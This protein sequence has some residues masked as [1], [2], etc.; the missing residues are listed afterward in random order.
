M[1]RFYKAALVVML[2]CGMQV[3]AQK[4]AHVQMD[5]LIQLMPETKQ[6]MDIAQAY[7]KDLEKQVSTMKAEF[8][9]K[10]QDYLTNKDNYSD[11][12]RKTKEEELQTLNQRIE[13][14][15][16]QAQQDYQK[17]YTELSKPI[18]EKAKKAIDIIAKE[19][20]Y[21]YVLDTS[22]GVVLFSEPGDDLLMAVK[23][24]MDTMPA[25][26]LPGGG[27]TTTPK[28]ET[29]KPQPKTGGTGGGK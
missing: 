13:D 28:K 17:K 4:I 25:A 10:Y 22:S 2:A 19:G 5:S 6:A 29:P 1:N 27:G 8:D 21:K 20:G 3:Q 7:L 16:Q 15:R 11:L 23:K 26:V 18:Q 14:F 9:S 24:K 12:V